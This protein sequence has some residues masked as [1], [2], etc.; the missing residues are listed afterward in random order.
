M[1]KHHEK[2]AKACDLYARVALSPDKRLARQAL[3]RIFG[4]IRRARVTQAKEA[5]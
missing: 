4:L 1:N 3:A 2:I 5:S